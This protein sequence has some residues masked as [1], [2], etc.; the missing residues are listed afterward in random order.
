MLIDNTDIQILTK[1]GQSRDL[2]R[3]VFTIYLYL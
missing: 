3:Y 2:L 1:G